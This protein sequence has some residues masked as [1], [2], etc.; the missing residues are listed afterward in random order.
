MDVILD[1]VTRNGS[2]YDRHFV[3]RIYRNEIRARFNAK[4]AVYTMGMLECAFDENVEVIVW[5]VSDER[6]RLDGLES[7]T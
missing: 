5:A 1:V 2:I 4:V 7:E 3:A 6:G